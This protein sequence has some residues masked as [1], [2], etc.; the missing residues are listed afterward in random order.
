MTSSYPPECAAAV[1]V[2][3][4]EGIQRVELANTELSIIFLPD[5]GNILSSFWHRGQQCEALWRNPLN[6]PRPL[7]GFS[8]LHARGSEFYDTFHGGWSLSLPAGFFKTDYHGAPLGILGEFANCRWTVA[9]IRHEHGNASV[10]FTVQGVRTPFSIRRIVQ[11]PARGCVITVKTWVKN[12]GGIRLP[13]VWLEHVLLGGELLQGGEIFS[14]ARRVDVPSSDRLDL[15][16]LKPDSSAH[17]PYACDSI[18][19]LRDLR[20]VPTLHSREEHV[21]M[22]EDL[23]SGSA[24]IWN[25]QRRLG[26][27]LS[28]DKF[29]FPRAW[30][31]CSGGASQGYPLWG[32]EHVVG[33]E[34]A[35]SS[36]RK[37]EELI[38]RKEV[39]WIEQDAT[40]SSELRC[41]FIE[42]AP[43][44]GS[45][46]LYASG[47]SNKPTC[48]G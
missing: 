25:A 8:G 2:Y 1:R 36:M 31:W 14:S 48:E 24:G 33:I 11:L 17:W 3:T 39:V 38:D 18:G 22:L 6:P 5:H 43:A 23:H 37:L 7:G 26:F 15:L 44:T 12:H 28:W 45:G 40:I 46:N 20:K 29:F 41:G 30:L 34:P 32:K 21:V 19:A 9:D 35:T 4:H 13:L 16:Q 42:R 10:E 27:E 47:E